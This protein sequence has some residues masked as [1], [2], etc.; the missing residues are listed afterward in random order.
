[1]TLRFI[2][3]QS[4]VDQTVKKAS[5]GGANEIKEHWVYDVTIENKTFKELS[6]LDLK[7]VV[8]FTQER[9]G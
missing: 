9:L 7:Y 8:F 1:M 3:F 5:D 6:D 4:G 2:V